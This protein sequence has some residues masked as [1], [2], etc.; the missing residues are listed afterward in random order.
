MSLQLVSHPLPVAWDGRAV[1][2]DRWENPQP[3]FIC[4][5]P[6]RK[7]CTCGSEDSPFTAR[8]RRD[9]S[10]ERIANAESLPRLGKRTP[11]VWSIYDLR[12]Y[13]CPACGEVSVWDMEADQFWTLDDSD[14]GDTGSWAWSGGLL[15]QLLIDSPVPSATKDGE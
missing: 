10:A 14:Y 1:A 3:M 13:R 4:P 15:D 7:R 8:G 6:K 11:L 9:P 5:T 12:A 2:W